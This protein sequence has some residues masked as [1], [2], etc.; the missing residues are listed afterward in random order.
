[1]KTYLISFIL[2]FVLLM[3][4]TPFLI[5]IGKKY[6]FVDKI[7]RR[8]VH[9]GL[10][11]RIG[12]IGIALGTLLPIALLRFHSNDISELFFSD[13]GNSIVVLGGALII[14]LMGLVDDIKEVSAK[15]KF[16]IQILVA[17]LAWHFGFSISKISIPFFTINFG[18]FSLPI[19][20]LWIVG[21]IN[22]FNLIDGLDGLSSGLAFFASIVSFVVA[23]HNNLLFP[24]FT[25]SRR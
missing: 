25:S 24:L 6:G 21:I 20:I 18:I 14:S 16:I 1:M 19:T 5:F 12:G 11:P 17:T 7:N 3:I 22:A 15:Y 4:F 8:K 9:S 10:I 23:V 13:I 2:S